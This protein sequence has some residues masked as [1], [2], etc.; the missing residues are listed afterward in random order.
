MQKNI[1]ATIAIVPT[2]ILLLGIIGTLQGNT[3]DTLDLSITPVTKATGSPEQHLTEE[4]LLTSA[5]STQTSRSTVHT[6]PFFSQFDDISHP[7][8]RRVGCGIAALAMLIDF[9]GPDRTSVDHLLDKGIAANAFL[10][11]AGWIHAGLISLA[12]EYG[13]YGDTYSYSHL[14]MPDAFSRLKAVMEE[15]PVMVSVHYTFDP[16]NP[17]PHLVVVNGVHDGRIYYNDPAEATGGGSISIERFQS[18]WKKRYIKLRP[19][20]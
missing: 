20:A 10:R 8:W 15:G 6:V 7:E 19:T 17:I 4:V 2:G 18:S 14:S 11:N 13:L 9:Y 12:N 1:I 16:K 3:T 5:S